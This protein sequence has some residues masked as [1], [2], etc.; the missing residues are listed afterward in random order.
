MKFIRILGLILAVIVHVLAY[1]DYQHAPIVLLPVVFEEQILFLLFFSLLLAVILPI[2]RNQNIIWFILFTRCGIL[3]FI[4]Q[5]LGGYLRIE[6]VLATNL[7]VE[8]FIYFPWRTALIY[9]LG[10]FA[11]ILFNNRLNFFPTGEMFWVDSANRSTLF[12][13]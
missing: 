11:I 1:L 2:L 13:W 9:S 3:L 12:Y 10:V 4:N 6:A 5:L 8:T 7:I